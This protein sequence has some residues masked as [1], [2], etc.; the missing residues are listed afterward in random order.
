MFI[1]SNPNPNNSR[2]GDCVIRAI[3]KAENASWD[4]I[5]LDLLNSL[6]PEED[7]KNDISTQVQ[8]TNTEFGGSEF[9]KKIKGHDINKVLSVLD[10]LMEALK[11][12]NPQLYANTL[13]RFE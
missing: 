11:A 6:Y 9:L 4:K 13:R 1:E 10:E 7:F 5:Y 3:A 12:L 8:N 2:V